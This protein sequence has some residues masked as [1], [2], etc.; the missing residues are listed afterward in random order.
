MQHAVQATVTGIVTYPVQTIVTGTDVAVFL[1]VVSAIVVLVIGAVII[2]SVI[3]DLVAICLYVDAI[4]DA[5][6]D[7]DTVFVISIIAMI[8]VANTVTAAI[9]ACCG[10]VLKVVVAGNQYGTIE[11]EGDGVIFAIIFDFSVVIVVT[12]VIFTA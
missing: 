8:V 6:V 2:Q 11:N 5:A 10:C 7:A 3:D 9:A 12:G 1:A 4:N